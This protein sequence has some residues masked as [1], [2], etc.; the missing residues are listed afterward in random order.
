[1][2]TITTNNTSEATVEAIAINNKVARLDY[3]MNRIE[4]LATME[5]RLKDWDGPFSQKIEEWK[6]LRAEM[7]ETR[8]ELIA[9]ATK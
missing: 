1:M 8:Q 5:M 7:I 3:L 2:N 4:N 9:L 6:K